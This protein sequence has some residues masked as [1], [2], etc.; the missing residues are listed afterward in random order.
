M[1][2]SEAKF[3]IT[4]YLVGGLIYF[5]PTFVGIVRAHPNR[6]AIAVVNLAFGATIIGW[7]GALIWALSA[8]HRSS[9]GNHGGESGLNLFVNDPDLVRKLPS[10]DDKRQELHDVS[11]LLL[12]L[13]RLV[14]NG[15]LLE[16]EFLSLK[17]SLLNRALGE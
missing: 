3:L 14:D 1:N 13:R 9:T 10:L 4:W 11:D 5:L 8:V 7:F 2:S 6:W 15:S 12:R 17:K 16:E